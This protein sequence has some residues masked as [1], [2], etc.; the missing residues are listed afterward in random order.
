MR[1]FAPMFVMTSILALA[2][3]NALANTDAK[4]GA[5]DK[6]TGSP[7]ATANS[8]SPQ[9][10]SYNDKGNT[11]TGTTAKMDAKAST[12]ESNASVS[13]SSSSSDKVAMDDK[14][15]LKKKLKKV[16]AKIARS[17]PEP[18]SP[19]SADTN[20]AAVKSTTGTSPGQ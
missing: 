10:T 9:G 14:P 12:S 13:T 19:A 5:T 15:T 17:G 3:G 18:M 16:K 1:K 4:A 2:G 6:M 11:A 8:S 20:G 7:T